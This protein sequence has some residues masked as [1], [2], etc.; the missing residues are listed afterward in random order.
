MATPPQKLLGNAEWHKGNVSI[1]LSRAADPTRRRIDLRD[2]LGSEVSADRET[3]LDQGRRTAHKLSLDALAKKIEPVVSTASKAETV[4]AWADRWHDMRLARKIVETADED[5]SHIRNHI[6]SVIGHRPMRLVDRVEIEAIVERL[7]TLVLEGR[8]SWK[9]A[10]NVWS[11]VRAM[12]RDAVNTKARELR[13]RSDNPTDGVE[14]PERGEKRS[15]TML[16]PSEYLD[17][18]TSP[19]IWEA[20]GEGR[21]RAAMM[22]RRKSARRWMRL[23]SIA[24]YLNLRAGEIRALR[25][26]GID[27]EHRVVEIHK[28]AKQGTRGKKLKDPKKGSKRTFEIPLEAMPLLDA[29]HAEACRAQGTEHPTGPVITVPPEEKLATYLRTLLRLAG[30]TR[31]ALFADDTERKP[32]TFHDLRATGITWRIMRGDNHVLVQGAAGHKSFAT[33]EGYIRATNLRGKGVGEPF[34]PI[35]AIVLG[36][37]VSEKPEVPRQKSE[38][39]THRSDDATTEGRPPSVPPLSP[40]AR[41]LLNSNNSFVTPTG[42]ETPVP[43]KTAEKTQ[44]RGT[45]D[46]PDPTDRYR[47]RAV[48][49]TESDPV[50]T[51]LRAALET[52]IAEGR[53]ADAAAIAGELA[54]RARSIHGPNVIPFASERRRR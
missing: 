2:V 6:A 26:E 49:G 4:L 18:M 34:P 42:I 32:L 37:N 5:R 23:I 29:M 46:P 15:T 14:P 35:P 12:F 50:S 33:T 17:L 51:V 25:W 30:C 16:Y 9:T 53:V 24:I 31:E 47:S 27:R 21:M 10:A 8:I 13:V 39:P 1:R 28:A 38:G 11:T 22:N 43:T 19:A 54:G 48:G 20:S 7:D 45:S 52:A 3:A 40:R 41:K 44:Q 36:S